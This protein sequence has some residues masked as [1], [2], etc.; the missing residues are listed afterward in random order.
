MLTKPTSTPTATSILDPTMWIAMSLSL[1]I[2]A[3]A[4]V[5]VSHL[6]S[7]SARIP[8]LAYSKGQTSAQVSV[9]F[10]SAEQFTEQWRPLPSTAQ[11]IDTSLSKAHIDAPSNSSV[12]PLTGRVRDE[13]T[14][15][16]AHLARHSP[17][18]RSA[19]P[20][21][22]LPAVDAKRGMEHGVKISH[23]SE[24][25][26]PLRSRRKGEEGTVL[27]KVEVLPDGRIGVVSI[28]ADPGYPRLVQAALTA[29]RAAHFTPA[30]KGGRPIRSVIRLPFQFVL[31]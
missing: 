29:V 27:L 18:S 8:R 3:A 4:I 28:L 26:Y 15:N 31:R 1:L 7:L 6:D 21:A 14:K 23:L 12:Q 2:H 19:T 17:T 25:E 5:A 22:P 16:L 9:R 10:L 30:I 20:P 24:P 13:P 11:S